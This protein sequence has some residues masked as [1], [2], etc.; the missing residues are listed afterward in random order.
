[1]ILLLVLFIAVVPVHSLQNLFP[2]RPPPISEELGCSPTLALLFECD[3]FDPLQLANDSNFSPYRESEL[4]HG[5]IAMLAMTQIMVS[6]VLHAA[7]LV[8]DDIVLD[9]PLPPANLHIAFAVLLVCGFLETFVLVRRDPLD[10]PGDYGTGYFG[11]RDK[12]TNEYQLL[13]ELEHGRLAMM[14]FVVFVTLDIAT[15]G[16][17]WLNF[18]RE[19][20]VKD[21]LFQMR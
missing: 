15:H 12:T 1:M 4:K 5:R 7:E 3:F 14:S 19:A 6:P 10:M 13:V 2:P 9:R 18:W 17:P 11:I 16:T 8:S 21:G 20:I